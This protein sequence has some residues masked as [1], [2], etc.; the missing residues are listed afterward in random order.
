MK[1][2]RRSLC[3]QTI[4]RLESRTLLSFSAPVPNSAVVMNTSLGEV[5]IQLYTDGTEPV[6]VSNFLSYV[7]AGTYNGTVFHRV[8]YN[9][10]SNSDTFGIVQGGGFT[11]DNGTLTTVTTNAPIALE[12]TATHPNSLGTIAMARTSSPD[13]A[14]SQFFFNTTDNSSI[15]DNNSADSSYNPYT[16][17]GT[18]IRGMGI[19][20]AVNNLSTSNSVTASDGETLNPPETSTGAFVTINSVTEEDSMTVTIGANDAAGT[21]SVTF[22]DPTTKSKVTISL[23]NADA[24]LTFTGTSMSATSHGSNV[25]VTGTN[26]QL[27]E[28][29]SSDSTAKTALK[30]SGNSSNLGDINITGS[31]N[32]ISGS[33]ANLSGDITTTGG[34][35]SIKLKG[36]SAAGIISLDT[37]EVASAPAT[38]ISIPA[39]SDISIESGGASKSLS[40]SQYTVDDGTSRQLSTNG[41]IA[42]VQVTGN[43]DAGVF[44]NAAVGSVKAGKMTDSIGGSTISSVTLGSF[45]NGYIYASGAYSAKTQG[46]SQIKISGAISNAEIVSVGN[47][48]SIQASSL[49]GTAIVAGYDSSGDNSPV[50]SFQYALAANATLQSVTLKTPKSASAASFSDSQ[51]DA[52]QIGALSLGRIATTNSGGTLT[53]AGLQSHDIQSFSTATDKNQSLNLSNI[54]DQT[55]VNAQIAQANVDLGDFV[56]DVI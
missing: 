2:R 42:K 31:I 26:L 12:A 1:N 35:N 25:L 46:I 24:T 51:I 37:G 44:S 14:T 3:I 39:L 22:L 30:I 52:Y 41:A 32:S 43:L 36:T 5:A 49:T 7:N 38:T 47:I 10:D 50:D 29:S 48:G 23:T 6:T 15:F 17:F 55:T 27:Q 18:V 33:G 20:Y 34:V 9:G 53:V 54:T 45:Q 11:D 21:K 4:Q 13:S 16:A 28:I 56:I 19:V 8:T 40:A